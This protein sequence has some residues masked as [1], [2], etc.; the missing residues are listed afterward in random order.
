MELRTIVTESSVWK[1]DTELRRYMRFPRGEDPGTSS[2]VPYQDG[3]DE[4]VRLERMGDRVMVHRPVPFGT[5]ALRQTG[6]IEWDDLQDTD[7]EEE[8]WTND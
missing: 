2:L 8:Q 5:G 4:Y 7:F 1:F 3:W 6:V